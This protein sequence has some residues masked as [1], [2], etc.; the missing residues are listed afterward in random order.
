[1]NNSAKT[2]IILMVVSGALLV[3]AFLFDLLLT[4]STGQFISISTSLCCMVAPFVFI[5]GFIVMIIGLV[6][7]KPSRPTYR[8]PPQPPRHPTRPPHAP[9]G[10]DPSMLQKALNYEKA[11]R[12]ED[13]AI[14]YEKLG[15]WEEA[16]RCRRRAKGKTVKHVHVDA[17]EL[18]DQ[19]KKQGL[20]VNYRC[21][22]CG[23]HLDI[24]G[25]TRL[26]YCT[27]CGSPIDTRT[28]SKMVDNLLR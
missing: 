2:G 11:E 23:G 3:I 12:W 21:P 8:P 27:F 18:F 24:D 20:A 25:S 17:N 9:H 1:M 7:N 15:L 4:V 13:A 14:I 5:A 28:L 16:G 6:Q 19:I 26:K 22:K 10:P